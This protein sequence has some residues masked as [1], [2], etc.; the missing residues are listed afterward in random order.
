M[1]VQPLSQRTLVLALVALLA[2]GLGPG[3]AAAQSAPTG[4]TAMAGSVVIETGETVDG[5][6]VMAGT[7]VVRGTV[8]G[9]L[10]GFAGDVVIAESGSV[11]GDLNVATGS[12]RIAGTVEGSVSAGAGSVLLTDAGSV[13]GDV[14]VGAG[15]VRIEGQI[16]GD[17]TV[18]A[19]SITLGPAARIGGELRYDGSLTQQSGSTVSGSV[20]EDDSIGGFGPV[21]FSGITLPAVGWLDTVYGLFANL[22]LGAVL[23]ALLPGFSTQV[24][25]RA[26]ESTGRSALVGLLAMIGV[27]FV[28]ALVAITIIGLPLSILGIFGYLL[29]LWT[30]VVYGEF[31]AGR[32][33]LGRLGGEP[34]RWAALVVGLGAFAVLGAIPVVG[35]LFVFAALLVG[36]GALTWGLRDTYRNRRGRDDTPSATGTAP[37]DVDG[38]TR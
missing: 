38:P 25:T 8:D 31:A 30:G 2:I 35:G 1:A 26:A 34:N 32:W 17:A 19:E 7:V 22:L 14:S 33:L 4:D 6:D 3:V 5:L 37:E 24:A 18:G 28:L 10:D 36:L 23:L 16:D 27:P 21:G 15:T 12:L 20:L 29:A 9:G 13:A 11:T